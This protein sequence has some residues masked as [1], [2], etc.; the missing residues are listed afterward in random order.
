MKKGISFLKY[1]AQKIERNAL[2]FSIYR[3]VK[4]PQVYKNSSKVLNG[5][6]MQKIG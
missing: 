6:V 4:H 2:L 3:S 1:T 5:P